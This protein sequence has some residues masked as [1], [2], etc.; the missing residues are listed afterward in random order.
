MEGHPTPPEAVRPNFN[1][2]RGIVMFNSRTLFLIFHSMLAFTNLSEIYTPMRL[3][4]ISRV[5][6]LPS[7]VESAVMKWTVTVRYAC[8]A[9]LVLMSMVRAYQELKSV[10][11][12]QGTQISGHKLHMQSGL[13]WQQ[14]VEQ[15]ASK[16][17]HSAYSAWSTGNQCRYNACTAVCALLGGDSSGCCPSTIS[18]LLVAELT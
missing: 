8:V 10:N 11:N 9:R 17:Y 16:T 7:I 14:R 13:L 18:K 5:R 1:H 2:V 12:A 6:T 15:Y 3:S 4:G